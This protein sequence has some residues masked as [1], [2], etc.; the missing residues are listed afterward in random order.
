MSFFRIHFKI[1]EKEF[2]LKSESLDMSHPY[3]VSMKDLVMPKT[4]KVL[5][6]ADDDLRRTFGNTRQV[7]IPFQSISYIEEFDRDPDE[8]PDAAGTNIKLVDGSPK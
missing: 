6:P 5:S 2:S 7:M 8:R 3:F 1:K 4:G